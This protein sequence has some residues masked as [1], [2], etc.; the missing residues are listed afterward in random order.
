MGALRIVSLS[1]AFITDLKSTEGWSRVLY[2]GEP[3]YVVDNPI[4]EDIEWCIDRVLD[5]NT[6]FIMCQCIPRSKYVR[7]K[8]FL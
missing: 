6:L 1:R 7:G 4:L 3:A 8:L 2:Q 5:V